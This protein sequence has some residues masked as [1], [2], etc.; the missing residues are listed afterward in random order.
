MKLYFTHTRNSPPPN[1]TSYST[2]LSTEQSYSFSSSHTPNTNKLNNFHKSFLRNR[3]LQNSKYQHLFNSSYLSTIKSRNHPLNESLSTNQLLSTTSFPSKPHPKTKPIITTASSFCSYNPTSPFQTTYNFHKQIQAIRKEKYILS[4]KKNKLH[5]K[6]C[7]ISNNIGLTEQN[8]KH[9]TYSS[10]LL[11]CFVKEY[12]LYLRHLEKV[13]STEIEK[14]ISL[15]LK[16]NKLITE[17]QRLK[18]KQEQLQ[19]TF[20]MNLKIKH[21]LIAVKN[22]T[23]DKRKYSIEDKKEIEKDEQ[24]YLNNILNPS[25]KNH[26]KELNISFNSDKYLLRAFTTRKNTYKRNNHRNKSINEQQ[27]RQHRP[28]HLQTALHNESKA[29]F[30]NHLK[31]KYVL[32]NSP[33]EF[34]RLISTIT[35]MINININKYNDIQNDITILKQQKD[36]LIQS[37]NTQQLQT[38]ISLCISNLNELKQQ[39]TNLTLIKTK[40]QSHKSISLNKVKLKIENIHYL[41][42]NT[43]M[44]CSHLKS[45]TKLESYLLSLLSKNAYLKQHH[46]FQYSLQKQ[47]QD[48]H[49]K[50]IS[51][52]QF[53]SKQQEQ[54]IE[55]INTIINHS[56]KLTYL[57]HKHSTPNEYMHLESI[58][59]KREAQRKERLLNAQLGC[60]LSDYI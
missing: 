31:Q 18:R 57:P 22:C 12:D 47:T 50:L 49:N 56:N 24:L 19:K 21:F 58:R 32:F 25:I 53:K 28:V 23:N 41:I 3:I 27:Q 42:F 20:E 48:K 54:F 38:E 29:F 44:T 15:K 5:K 39:H 10:K 45:L 60:A 35:N 6:Q 1:H 46:P 9:C 8:M 30:I 33:D 7:N 59:R 2:R 14:C 26:N 52:K 37:N 17:I 11:N 51:I 4:L 34:N 36:T 43:E 55:K 16:R 13:K 40:L